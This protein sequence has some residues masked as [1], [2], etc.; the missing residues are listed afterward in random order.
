[1]ARGLTADRQTAPR[2]HRILWQE[3]S[4]SRKEESSWTGKEN[5]SRGAV[6]SR[7]LWL[8]V[9]CRLQLPEAPLDESAA[10]RLQEADRAH[11]SANDEN[12][13]ADEECS[14]PVPGPQQ[15]LM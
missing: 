5:R 1:S 15:L 4:L 9:F 6:E 3:G 2:L 14:A 10:G 7:T 13:S 12:L 8:S 11:L